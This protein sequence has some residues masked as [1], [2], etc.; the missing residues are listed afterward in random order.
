MQVPL[1]TLRVMPKPDATLA[2]ITPVSIEAVFGESP[3][4]LLYSVELDATLR[5][6]EKLAY[7]IMFA[8]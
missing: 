6:L 2:E 4:Y 7:Q 1:A 8:W 3:F 5:I